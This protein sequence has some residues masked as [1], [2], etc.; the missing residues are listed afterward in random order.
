[1]ARLILAIISTL[2]EETALV[3]IVLLGLPRLGIQIP[4]YGLIILMVLWLGYSVTI[5]QLGSRALRKKQLVGLP[6]MIGSKGKVV[7]TLAPEGL[8]RIR[9]EL[10]VAESAGGEIK[11]GEQ[12]VVVGQDSLKLMVQGSDV[13]QDSD[14][15]Q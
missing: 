4:L 11:S 10:W 13:A 2:L 8:V 14:K 3:V 9:G 1:M 7:N 15:A 5:Y 12:V 6:G